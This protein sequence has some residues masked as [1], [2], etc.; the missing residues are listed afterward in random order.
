MQRSVSY[1]ASD[2]IRETWREMIADDHEDGLSWHCFVKRQDTA[3]CWLGMNCDKNIQ[4]HATDPLCVVVVPALW[5]CICRHSYRNASFLRRTNRV[6]W[7]CWVR[8]TLLC[9][10]NVIKRYVKVDHPWFDLPVSIA[11]RVDKL[12]ILGSI[13]RLALLRCWTAS[14]PKTATSRMLHSYS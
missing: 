8:A 10:E 2:W 14:S 9:R 4:K 3:A 7:V 13:Y 11:K 12:I 6:F 1:W 5:L